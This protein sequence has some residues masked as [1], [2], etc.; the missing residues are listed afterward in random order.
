[1]DPRHVIEG[2]SSD[3]FET[4][5]ILAVDNTGPLLVLTSRTGRAA[6]TET[7]S[8]D[9]SR[10]VEILLFCAV[11]VREQ[12]ADSGVTVYHWWF[13]GEGD[14]DDTYVIRI[15]DFVDPSG[16][17]PDRWGIARISDPSGPQ[18]GAGAVEL[19]AEGPSDSFDTISND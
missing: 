1:V 7:L 5:E 19:T 14:D 16:D 17:H 6:Y 8:D 12:D 11:T 15:E 18:C 10:H 2:D 3:G 9:A 13:W 4:L